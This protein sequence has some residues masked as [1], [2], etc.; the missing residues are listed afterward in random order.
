MNYAEQEKRLR[1]YRL[2]GGGGATALLALDLFAIHAER[3]PKT[4]EKIAFIALALALAGATYYLPFYLNLTT[5]DEKRLRWAVKFRWILCGIVAAGGAPFV[6]GATHRLASTLALF[7][8]VAA[9]AT[10][11]AFV[12]ELIRRRTDALRVVPKI[13][14]LT[15]AALAISWTWW[16]IGSIAF[17]SLA[18]QW[19]SLCY[20]VT[21]EPTRAA[22]K[23]AR[24]RII[25]FAIAAVAMLAL[26]I[27]AEPDRALF[28]AAAA[29][30]TC[31]CA[32]EL[33][34][35]FTFDWHAK[36]RAGVVA[37]IAAF[38]GE[39]H[40]RVCRRLLEASGA[41]AENWRRDR[42]SS[43]E[44]IVAWYR[45]NSRLYIYD[46]ANFHLYGKHVRFTL[47]LLKLARGRVLDYGAGIGDLA[48]ELARRG[49]AVVHF[50]LD[51][52]ARSF[53]IWRA[54]R[55]GLTNV[56]F[57]TKTERI[58]GAFETIYA[59]DVLEHL[60]DPEDTLRFLVSKLA[61]RGRLILTAP[62]GATD[63]HPMHLAPALDVR[64]FLDQRGLREAKGWR[65]WFGPAMIRRRHVMIYRRT[66]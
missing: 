4:V 50:D 51:G 41:L 64:R 22:W 46:L 5:E 52:D 33:L 1:L 30:M 53:A 16:K 58:G 27:V 15:D 38:T 29:L 66:D 36:A 63:A 6:V 34:A 42:P 45:R 57:P 35:A 55:E 17:L 62:F 19:A 18:L 54:K 61:P 23:Q 56:D 65:R 39:A 2:I 11:N 32:C 40:E 60:P 28:A 3:G 43:P 37:E 31:W 9:I 13:Y 7:G 59:L 48:L 12:R 14:L 24:R 21:A 44:E 26:T 49:H 47:E 25:V 10:V 20:I 8:T